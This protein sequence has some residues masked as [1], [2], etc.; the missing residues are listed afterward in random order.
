MGDDAGATGRVDPVTFRMFEDDG[1]HRSSASISH[2]GVY[3]YD[4]VRQWDAARG[5]ALWIMLNPSTADHEHDDPTIRRVRG[6]TE[7]EGFGGFVVV[8]L[9][10][11]RT[12]R[13]VHLL[14]AKDPIGPANDRTVMTWLRSSEISGIVAAWGAWWSAVPRKIPRLVVEAFT[15]RPIACLGKT[16]DGSPRHP[17][18]VAANTPMEAFR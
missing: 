7:R 6:F 4:L 18:Y 2:D 3:R 14:E 11:F 8:N 15:E 13:P 5:L 1:E 12:T 9:F 10:A 17:L 16:K